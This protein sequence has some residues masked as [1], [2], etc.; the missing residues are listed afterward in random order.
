MDEASR[1]F[2]ALLDAPGG[3]D[4]AVTLGVLVTLWLWH[5]AGLFP[6]K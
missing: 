3:Y 2:A 6:F 1:K 4:A 5:G